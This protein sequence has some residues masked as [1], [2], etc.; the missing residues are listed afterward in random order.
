MKKRRPLDISYTEAPSPHPRAA[1]R[2]EVGDRL[3]GRLNPIADTRAEAAVET[4]ANA[5]IPLWMRLF[6]GGIIWT[7]LSA[8]AARKKAGGR[9]PFQI[10]VIFVAAIVLCLLLMAIFPM[11]SQITS[12]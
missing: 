2:R 10:L 6:P 7:M 12:N 11:T 4:S 3:H 8:D 1:I 9:T 5:P